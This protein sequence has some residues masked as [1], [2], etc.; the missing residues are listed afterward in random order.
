[1][2]FVI[3][4]RAKMKKEALEFCLY[5]TNAQN[6]L[7]LA[8]MTNIISTNSDALN[9]KFYNDNSDL[10]SKARSISAK[11]LNH[12]YPQMKQRRGQK[13]I[14]NAVNS[15]VQT[16]LLD[17]NSTENTLDKLTKDLENNL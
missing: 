13:E 4:K 12:I 16:I 7:E 2:N 6:Q 5:L 1:M 17:K 15:A 9:D 14:N 3:P 11:Q 8:K 10:I